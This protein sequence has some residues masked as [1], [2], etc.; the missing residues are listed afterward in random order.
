MIMVQGARL[1]LHHT[2]I[3]DAVMDRFSINNS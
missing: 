1:D 3:V 2:R